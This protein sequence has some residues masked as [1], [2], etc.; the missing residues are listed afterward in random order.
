[1]LR[2]H[3]LVLRRDVPGAETRVLAD[4]TSTDLLKWAVSRT[5]SGARG[6]A[7]R[8][9]PQQQQQHQHSTSTT[10]SSSSS[11]SSSSSEQQ[12]QRQRQQQHQLH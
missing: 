1:M 8:R 3:R 9:L 5:G 10:G 7:S 2:L 12:Q 4:T 6:T 11:S